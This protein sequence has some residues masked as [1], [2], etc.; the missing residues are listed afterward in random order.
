MARRLYI[1]TALLLVMFLAASCK[2]EGAVNKLDPK[3]VAATVEEAGKAADGLDAMTKRAFSLSL[4]GYQ[5]ASQGID[6]AGKVL[7]DALA[8]AKEARSQANKAKYAGLKSATEEWPATDKEQILPLLDRME[9]ATTRVWATRAAAEGV[10]LL[11]KGKA[12]AVLTEAATEAEAIPDKKYRDM[13]LRGVA[14]TLATIDPQAAVEVARKIADPRIKSAA[15]TEIGPMAGADAAKIL[16]E[17]AD[18]AVSVTQMEPESELITPETPA[19]TKAKV[20]DAQ[21]SKLAEAAAKALAAAGQKM[22]AIDAQAARGM[23]AKAEEIA[24]GIAHRFTKAY[25]MSDVAI[26]LAPVDTGAAEELAGKIDTAHSDAI[27]AALMKVA[28]VKG[29]KA[30]KADEDA[31]GKAEA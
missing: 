5:M 21:K 17:A 28:E 2:E 25:A 19:A 24:G 18:A 8:T 27:F 3:V 12:K 31:L 30:G 22:N 13:D 26:T 4:V 15:L 10:A 11:D 16:A 6:G 29:A 1:V 9:K 20:L 7:D 23:F 14:A